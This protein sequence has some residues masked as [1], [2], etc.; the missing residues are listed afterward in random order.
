MLPI[1]T[2]EQE[3]HSDYLEGQRAT[4]RWVGALTVMIVIVTIIVIASLLF[5]GGETE[6]E[7]T[8]VTVDVTTEIGS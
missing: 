2:T 8:D 6:T 3:R 1:P 5:G 7:P 4:N